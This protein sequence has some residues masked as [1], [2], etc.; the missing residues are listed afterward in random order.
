MLD[1]LSTRYANLL[2]G[3]YDCVDRI[4]LNAYFQFGQAPASFRLWWRSLR[5]S[6]EELDKA[7][8]MRMAGRF[9]RRV[10]AHAEAHQIPVVDCAAEERKHVFAE[11]YLPTDPDFV[12]VFVIL[13][14]RAPVWDVQQTKSGTIV[15]IQR[16]TQYV[17]HY[18]FHI[19]DPDWGHVTIRISGHPPFGAQVILNGHDYVACQARRA[20]IRFQ[21]EDNCFTDVTDAAQLAQLADTLRTPDVVGSL[22][23]VCER[24]IYSSCPCFALDAEEQVRSNFH[25]DYSV[26][27]AEYS[28][29]LLFRH[30]SQLEQLFQGLVDRTRS[31]LD[32]KRVQTIFGRKRRPYRHGQRR[33]QPRF[34]VVVERP[35]YD[36]TVFKLHFGKLTVKLYTKGERVLRSEAIVHNT[37]ALHCGRSLPKFPQVVTELAGILQHFLDALDC[38]DSAFIA[39]DTFDQLTQPGYVGQTRVAGVDLSKPRMRAVIQA[40]LA[41][42]AAPKGF[43]A[44]AVAAQVRTIRGLNAEAYR[45]RHAAY[46]LKKLRGKNWVRTVGKSRSYEVVPEGLQAMTAILVLRDKVI[47]PVL[48]AS[49]KPIQ[50][51]PPERLTPLDALYRTLQGDMCQ[52]LQFLGI[53]VQTA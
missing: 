34:E 5:G 47:K 8:L 1:R 13:V 26:Y 35:V 19:L 17:K 25:Y 15:N 33:A 9:A 10:R 24:W 43:F 32:V 11:Q 41:L 2:D 6:D 52:L 28:R 7:H 50:T 36:L 53:A 40:V 29:N 21:K 31:W 20:G 22:R 3:T 48:A 30:G 46:D 49:A 12:G 51:D 44:A 45:A 27:Q 18:Y 37:K 23:Q 14:G 4:V 16:K 42:A 38:V 39:D